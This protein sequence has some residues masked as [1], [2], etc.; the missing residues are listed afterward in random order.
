[1]TERPRMKRVFMNI[2]RV[3]QH[4]LDE[5]TKHNKK[6]G[7]SRP[8]QPNQLRNI[9]NS[10]PP[11]CPRLHLGCSKTCANL[12]PGAHLRPRFLYFRQ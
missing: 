11:E 10:M 6:G 3:L 5:L 9:K 1:M 8:D 7:Q 2:L 4:C 12:A